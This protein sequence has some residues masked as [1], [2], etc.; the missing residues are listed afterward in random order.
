MS[1]DTQ[2]ATGGAGAQPSNPEF[3]PFPSADKL[4]QELAQPG[5]AEQKQSPAQGD[6]TTVSAP[7][8]DD[9]FAMPDKFKGKSAEDVARSY[10]ELEGTLRRQSQ[11]VGTLRG[12]VED[13]LELKR[14]EDLR[15]NGGQTGP[16][17]ISS[18]DVLTDPR[19][20]ISTVAGEQ[21]APV[22]DRVDGIEVK[23]AMRDFRDRHPTFQT[24][25]QDP[26]F[27]EF[28]AASPYRQSLSAKVLETANQGNPDFAAAEELW[29]AWDEHKAGL[30]AAEGDKGDG[31]KEATTT[32]D[33]STPVE[34]AALA[35]AG[36][37]ETEAQS[38]P[39][40]SREEIIRIMQTDR[41]RYESPQF[42]AVYTKALREGR[43]R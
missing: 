8:S 10:V 21:V 3:T 12:L 43:V 20:A 27:Q 40:Y 2:N 24:D 9:S 14:T 17:E 7:A 11:E 23:L 28:V 16:A 36:G 26:R 22:N 30:E 5:P 15:N 18:D 13:V 25:P 37:V 4:E 42:Q 38:G 34:Q 29:S 41:A 39:I 19:N 1:Q 33:N 6:E 35:R 31:G 32:V